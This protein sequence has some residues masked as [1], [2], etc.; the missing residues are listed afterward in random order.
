MKNR[1]YITLSIITLLAIA[2]G[3]YL[4]ANRMIDSIYAYRSPISAESPT[5]GPVI[6]KPLSEKV[7]LILIDAL[8]VDTSTNSK[9][10]P[11]LNQ[12]LSSGAHAVMHSQTPSYSAPGYSTIFTG[13]WPYMNNGPAFNLDYSEIPVWTQDNLFSAAHRNGI[14]TG[15]A[16]YNWFE[17]LVPQQDV[18]FKF[19]TAG[20]DNIADERVV[21]AAIGWLEQPGN[22]FILVHIDQVDYAGHHEGGPQGQAWMD[23][24]MRA[25]SLV[26]RIDSRL[27]LTKDTII[28]LSDHG[29]IDPGGHGGHEPIVLVEPFIMA[30]K[31]VIPGEYP[32]VQMVDVAPT[33]SAL[34]GANIPSSST[35]NVISGMLDL[36]PEYLN[37]YLNS[38][39]AIHNNI[40]VVYAKAINQPLKTGQSIE[41][42]RQNRLGKER[43]VRLP[44]TLFIIIIPPLLL[45]LRK[46]KELKYWVPGALISFFGFQM[47]YGI[48]DRKSYSFSAILTPSDLIIYC[49]I[50]ASIAL[51]IGFIFILVF[52][53]PKLNDRSDAAKFTFGYVF[54]S[55]Y[56]WLLPLGWNFI[57]NGF[58]PTWTLPRLDAYFIGLLSMVIL[59]IVSISGLLITLIYSLF[60]RLLIKA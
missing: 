37:V 22:Q 55:L 48:I 52:L 49:A 23:A 32:D 15:I 1:T 27:D 20:E 21:A 38:E 24:A 9:V 30:G 4:G 5:P 3:A 46:S 26:E 57:L 43:W 16:A 45:L 41:S 25:D 10:M 40:S 6:G 8:R 39:E 33:I 28:V 31:G 35:G 51:L 54:T 58:I 50:T 19:Y 47:R 12:L 34:L 14:K 56:L 29:Q 17:K 2:I 59:I 7:V 11:Y 53:Q 13:A 18:D 60:S 36:S 44:I 42:I